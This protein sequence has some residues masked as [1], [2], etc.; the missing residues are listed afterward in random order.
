MKDES[1]A[2]TP[3]NFYLND[4]N[5][6]VAAWVEAQANAYSSVSKRLENS[7]NEPISIDKVQVVFQKP[8]RGWIDTQIFINGEEKAGFS[9]SD[10]NNP[11][12]GIIT[13][14]ETMAE[15]KRPW[16]MRDYSFVNDCEREEIVFHA[17]TLSSN[18]ID[19]C[20]FIV[21]NSWTDKDNLPMSSSGVAIVKKEELIAAFYR[22]L[23]KIFEEMPQYDEDSPSNEWFGIERKNGN[24]SE[25]V[26]DKDEYLRL[27]KNEKIEEYLTK[28]NL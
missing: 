8:D 25:V 20:I 17:Q 24:I 9:L 14:L 6:D 27:I 26:E 23:I 16:E 22:P 13:W 3:R 18:G 21:F 11:V 28:F 5:L 15:D 1:E 12:V 7:L 2:L 10:W 4:A 19:L